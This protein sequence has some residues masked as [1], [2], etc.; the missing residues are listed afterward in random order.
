MSQV[1]HTK[2]TFAELSNVNTE[3]NN[4]FSSLQTAAEG[5]RL[6][7]FRLKLIQHLSMNIVIKENRQR[8]QK[9]QFDRMIMAS[10]DFQL[11]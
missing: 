4:L 9:E 11:K 6:D 2:S 1:E 3:R 8:Y 5:D 10:Q 7:T